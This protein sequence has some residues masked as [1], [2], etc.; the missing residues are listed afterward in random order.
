MRRSSYQQG[1]TLIE[2]VVALVVFAVAVAGLVT[3]LPIS[4]FSDARDYNEFVWEARSCA[5]EI[6]ALEEEDPAFSIGNKGS[7]CPNDPA[8]WGVEPTNCTGSDAELLEVSCEHH[9]ENNEY[10]QIEIDSEGINDPDISPLVLQFDSTAG[11][12]GSPD[13]PGNGNGPPDDPGSGSGP[14]D[15]P[16]NGNGPPDD[17]GSGSG[18]PDDPGNSNRP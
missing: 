5:E 16:G 7:E 8:N 14:P 6:I 3:A 4:L 9:S 17:P 13:A 18:P 1:A 11:G 12:N 10:F 2:L 15:D